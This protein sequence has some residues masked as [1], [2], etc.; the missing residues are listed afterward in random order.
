MRM[1]SSG[2][3]RGRDTSCVERLTLV[4]Q[5]RPLVVTCSFTTV[6]CPV[7]FERCSAGS[8][9][10]GA[11]RTLH[12]AGRGDCFIA[13]KVSVQ[14]VDVLRDEISFDAVPRQKGQRFLKNIQFS[15]SWE[16]IEHEQQAMTIVWLGHSTFKRKSDRRKANNHVD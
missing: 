2:V 4:D 1:A 15:K 3:S 13:P 5:P 7:S 12:V 11:K 14:L 10:L 6:V 9:R 16:L 8:M